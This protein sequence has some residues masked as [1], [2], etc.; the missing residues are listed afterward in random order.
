MTDY[1]INETA[2]SKLTIIIKAYDA[3]MKGIQE[4][5]LASVDRAY[6]GIVRA[7]K[8]VLV[9]NIATQLIDI[10]W[11]D[12]LDQL[13]SRL[14]MNKTKINIGIKNEYISKIP[15]ETVKKYVGDHLADHIYKFGTDVHVFIDDKLVLPIE[16]KAYTE[17]AMLKRILFDAS[18]MKEATGINNYFLLQL[19]S[20]LGGD[21]STLNEIIY[22]SKPSH[23]ILSHVDINLE[24]ITLLKGE[25][26]VMAPIHKTEFYKELTLFQLERALLKFTSALEKYKKR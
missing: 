9:E 3:V 17:N 20:Q 18:L 26:K 8:G 25:R 5:A 15:N 13:S 19:E 23:A 7:G 24:I 2:K 12:I 10:A 4:E 6:G 21:Y 22:G 11:N 1:L 14:T 16:C